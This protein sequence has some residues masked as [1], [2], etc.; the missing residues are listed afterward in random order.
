MRE[1]NHLEPIRKVDEYNV[2]RKLVNWHAPDVSAR[3]FWTIALGTALEGYATG[4]DVAAMAAAMREALGDVAEARATTLPALR[5]VVPGNSFA[6]PE[7]RVFGA[8]QLSGGAGIVLVGLASSSLIVAA[9]LTILYW[10]A[11]TDDN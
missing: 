8:L 6:R 10:L 7:G 1:G 11:G 5:L 9:V 2:V 3:R 4:R